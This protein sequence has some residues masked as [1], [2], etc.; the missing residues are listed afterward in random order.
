MVMDSDLGELRPAITRVESHSTT[1]N[2]RK[3]HKVSMTL[4][5]VTTRSWASRDSLVVLSWYKFAAPLIAGVY[6]LGFIE[7][8]TVHTH[9]SRLVTQRVSHYTSSWKVVI[10]CDTAA[11]VRTHWQVRAIMDSVLAGLTY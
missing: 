2:L 4:T 1:Q 6:I 9:V 5:E 3:T 11:E 10:E 8:S 7:A